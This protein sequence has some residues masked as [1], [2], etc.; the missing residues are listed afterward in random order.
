M[1]VEVKALYR[2]DPIFFEYI[3][4]IDRHHFETMSALNNVPFI[5]VCLEPN[6]ASMQ[7]QNAYRI[8]ACRLFTNP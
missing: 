7:K 5:Q 3:S 6:V 4:Q 8:S 1:P 2:E